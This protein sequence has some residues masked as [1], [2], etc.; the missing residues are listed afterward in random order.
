VS[1]LTLFYYDEDKRALALIP[2]VEN[3]VNNSHFSSVATTP[4]INY[5]I[6]KS[7][8]AYL[9]R[10]GRFQKPV[11]SDNQRFMN[12]L[13]IFQVNLIKFKH[14]LCQNQKNIKM[15]FAKSLHSPTVYRKLYK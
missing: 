1:E 9:Y 4:F 8:D 12:E 14:L 13:P 15:A 3:V 6:Q 7:T 2:S 10:Y 5:Y 11:R